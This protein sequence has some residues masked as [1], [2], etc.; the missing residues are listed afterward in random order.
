MLYFILFIISI[1]MYANTPSNYSW[2]FCFG[3]MLLFFINAFFLLRNDIVKKNYV[4]FNLIFSFSFFWVSFAYPVFIYDTPLAWFGVFSEHVNWEFLS[5]A[6][7]VCLLFYSSYAFAYKVFRM[8]SNNG[9]NI[10]IQ[11]KHTRISNKVLNVIFVLFIINAIYALISNYGHTIG[12]NSNPFLFE[13][14]YTA[15]SANLVLYT[16]KTHLHKSF[17]SFLKENKKAIFFSF[18][19]ILLFLYMG[20]RGPVIRIGIILGVIYIYYYK[21]INVLKLGLI[22]SL[23]IFLMDFISKSRLQTPWR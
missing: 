12:V 14:F 16:Q 8:R 22:A 6:S 1:I 4:S 13:F 7:S 10:D 3:C 17:Y 9:Y 23:G 2:N 15:L 5:K 19:S 21:S 11:P 18:V 20:D